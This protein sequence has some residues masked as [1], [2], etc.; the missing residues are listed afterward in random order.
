MTIK[1]ELK[2]RWTNE[3]PKFWKKVQKAGIICAALGGAIA[4][5]PIALPAVAVTASGY[6]ATVGVVASI[7]SKLTVAD[8][9]VL[10]DT[11]EVKN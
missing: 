11:T 8:S 5:A 10:E 4:T 6:L 7:L 9:T 1:N 3:T 2:A